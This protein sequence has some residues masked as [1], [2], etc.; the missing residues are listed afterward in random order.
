LHV[1][2][3][4]CKGGAYTLRANVSSAE[5]GA[6]LTRLHL[7]RAASQRA[8]YTLSANIS[9]AKLR[10][11]LS[12]LHILRAT[13]QRPADI[14][15]AELRTNLSGLYTLRAARQGAAHV[16]G[17]E[18]CAGL[19]GLHTLWRK[20]RTHLTSLHSSRLEAQR[21]LRGTSG[22]LHLWNISALRG[23]RARHLLT[24]HIV[25]GERRDHRATVLLERDRR[26]LLG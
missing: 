18:L 25:A 13:L 21:H 9:N 7:L 4:T 1:L 16:L 11:N 20:L 3:A 8:T 15:G 2:W 14:G 17:G 10:A 12:G 19:P 6:D 5:G 23:N 26:D 24:R 22:L